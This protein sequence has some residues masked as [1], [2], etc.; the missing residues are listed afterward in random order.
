MDKSEFLVELSESLQTQFGKVDFE[1]QSQSQ[2][3]FSAIGS[4]ETEN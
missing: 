3:V 2:K 1:L 4:L